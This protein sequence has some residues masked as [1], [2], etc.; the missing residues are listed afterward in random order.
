VTQPAESWEFAV[1]GSD[2]SSEEPKY[3]GFFQTMEGAEK[4]RANA[5]TI[6]WLNVAVLDGNG[7]EIIPLE[8]LFRA[9]GGQILNGKTYLSISKALRGLLDTDLSIFE[10]APTFFGMTAE[11]GLELAQ[12]TIARLYDRTKGTVTIHRMLEQAK[13]EAQSFQRGDKQQVAE[14]IKE[15]ERIASRLDPIIQR[16]RIRRNKWFAHLDV[17]TVSDPQ[18]LNKIAEL[19]IPD[20]D[21]VFRETERILADLESLFDGTIGEIRYLGGDD[22]KG[23]LERIRQTVQIE[24]NQLEALRGT[25]SAENAAEV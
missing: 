19:T 3:L 21:V 22:Y 6:G 18:E 2:A 23:M 25:S 17:R 13:R 10:T 4:F 14:A 16:V 9:I 5:K 11:G 7:N 1:I 15:A 12:M 8:Q 20:L 24:K